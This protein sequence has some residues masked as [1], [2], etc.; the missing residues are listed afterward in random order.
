MSTS[1]I[2][3]LHCDHAQ[4]AVKV[5]NDRHGKLYQQRRDNGWIDAIYT[6][7]CPEHGGTILAH[8]AKLTT[9]TRG[10]GR[11]ERTTW[12]LTC[13]CGWTPSPAWQMDSTNY[14][15]ERHLAHL[16]EQTA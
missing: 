7:G 8:A 10:R 16:R 3:F 15:R 11:S 9:Q 1:T 14:L 12:F 4:C 6:H 13:A 2:E 5:E